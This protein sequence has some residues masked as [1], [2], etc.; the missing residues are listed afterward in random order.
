VEVAER[1]RELNDFIYQSWALESGRR[2]CRKHRSASVGFALKRPGLD[3][4]IA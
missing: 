1:E 3:T 4:R 2:G